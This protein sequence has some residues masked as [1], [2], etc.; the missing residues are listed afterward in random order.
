MTLT[1][2]PRPIRVFLVDDHEV[3]RLGIASVLRADP[4][5]EVVGEAANFHTALRRV[6]AL[7]PE[8][9][10]VDVRLPDGSGIDLCRQLRSLNSAIKCLLFTAYDDDE[11]SRSAILAGA[12]GYILKNVGAFDL[13]AAVRAV[14]GGATLMHQMAAQRIRSSFAAGDAPDPRFASLG[15]RERQ[16]LALIGEGLTNRQIGQRLGLAE[17]T[18]KNYVSGLLV[19]LGIERRT[20][21]A[22]LNA[23]WRSR[24]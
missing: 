9:M 2:P 8:V 23:Q 7:A 24:G 3:V 21:A 4:G 11:A 19:K 14:A 15:L 17:K 13:A 5:L 20:Q 16:I 1:I 12:S 22:I 18:I 10:I 6:P